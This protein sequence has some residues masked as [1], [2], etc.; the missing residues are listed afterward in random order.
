MRFP[1]IL[2]GVVLVAAG[3]LVPALAPPLKPVPAGVVGMDH[4]GYVVNGIDS[5]DEVN[6]PEITIH[7]GDTITF[8][9]SS[10]WIHVIGP[11]EKGLLA[12]PGMGAMTPR[13]MMEE[14]DSY[15]TPPWTTPG[16]YQITCT[17]HPDMD[18]KVV[19]LP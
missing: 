16:T 8:Q 10:R 5:D 12:A 1:R 9:N 2:L 17:V 13:K 6:K 7:A 14:N 15:T 11:G 3:I 4:D 19:V 18:A